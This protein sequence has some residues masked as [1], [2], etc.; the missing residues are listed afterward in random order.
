MKKSGSSEV[1]CSAVR[2]EC[3]CA[4]TSIL[5]TLHMFNKQNK[6][7]VL[8]HLIE[9]FVCKSKY[10]GFCSLKIFGDDVKCIKIY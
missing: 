8:S 3:I 1:T 5:S 9:V 2:A 4:R 6:V 7:H 10:E